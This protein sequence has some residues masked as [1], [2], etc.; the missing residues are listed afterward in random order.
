MMGGQFNK[1]RARKSACQGDD[2]R[3]TY[4][5]ID[6][7]CSTNSDLTLIGY[8]D[9]C[10]E[11]QSRTLCIFDWDDTLFPTSSLQLLDLL[12]G[13]F[14]LSKEQVEEFLRLADSVENILRSAL[15][16]GRVVIVTN[17]Q[18]GWVEKCCA[19]MMPSLLSLF[20]EVD[21]ISARSAYESCTS[22]PFEWKRLAFDKEAE[23]LE[24]LGIQEYTLISLGDSAYE[25]RAIKA[26]SDSR[27]SCCGK[28]CKFMQKPTVEELI[29][30]HDFMSSRFSEFVE[31]SGHI[32]IKLCA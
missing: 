5:D 31:Y 7:V 27:P 9:S 29:M 20:P 2:I 6:S 18:K 14:V 32:D 12:Y 17:A 19:R 16:F 15:Q 21:I 13:D 8:E 4:D 11:N 25:L 23:T 10:N 30:Q 22:S 1:P 24:T 26:I 3:E 28:S